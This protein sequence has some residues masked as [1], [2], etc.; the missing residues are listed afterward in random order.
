MDLL[1][2]KSLVLDILDLDH[3]GIIESVKNTIEQ[4]S[5]ISQIL[6]QKVRLIKTHSTENLTLIAKLLEVSK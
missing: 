4:H 3:S 1:G 6:E 5:D 2:Q